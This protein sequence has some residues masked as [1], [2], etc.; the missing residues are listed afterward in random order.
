MRTV[1]KLT[2]ESDSMLKVISTQED[3]IPPFK[4]Q[5][6]GRIRNQD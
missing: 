3:Y 5:K 4:S 1:E 6:H 2:Y